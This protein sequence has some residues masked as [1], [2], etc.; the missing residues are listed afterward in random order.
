MS[1]TKGKW[2]AV[3]FAEKLEEMRSFI[4]REVAGGFSDPEEIR[5]GA[6]ELLAKDN[7][8]DEL[9][10]YAARMF[11]EEL[12]AHRKS[13]IAW[14][15]VTDCDRLEAAFQE[16]ERK[17]IVCRQN[18]SCCGTCGAGEIEAEI[19]SIQAEGKPARG[20][21]FYHMQD[22]DAAVR[23]EGLYLNYG[24][25]QAGERPALQVAHEIVGALEQQGLSVQWDGT[26][27]TRIH[28]QLDWK[29]RR[30]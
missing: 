24:A 4:R 28:V 20:Y 9:R 17:G 10:E 25:A 19:E 22:T 5:D 8:A 15:P 6:V 29:R 16:L 7:D 2:D 14:P 11:R 3:E 13:Q 30:P 26:W 1:S 18:F 27:A 21:V 23:G 12:E